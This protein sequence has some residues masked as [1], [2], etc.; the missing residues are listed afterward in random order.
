MGAT[1]VCLLNESRMIR[2]IRRVFKPAVAPP[3]C[4]LSQWSA[5]AALEGDLG[6][7]EAAGRCAAA[8]TP[9]QPPNAFVVNC[10]NM[11]P[12]PSPAYWLTIEEYPTI[13]RFK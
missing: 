1:P 4:H 10:A 5:H 3:G 7:G 13:T 9:A 6:L 2:K 11:R 12:I 8:E